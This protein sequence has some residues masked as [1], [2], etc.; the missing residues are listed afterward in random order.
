MSSTILATAERIVHR[1]I[2]RHGLEADAMF[3]SAGLDPQKLNEPQARYPLDRSRELW[4]QINEQIHDPCW[5]LAA[6]DLWRPT[7]F[8]ALGYAYLA[9][10]TLESALKRMERYFRIVIPVWSL[11][12]SITGDGFSMTHVLLPD[13]VNFPASQDA[14]LSIALRMCRDVYGQEFS[15]REVRLA[16]PWQACGYEDFFGCPVRYD[17]DFAGFTVPLDV[18]R[19]PL[20]AKNRDLARENDRILQDL[21]R[22]LL[23]GSM[24]GRVK[25]AILDSR[26]KAR[27]LAADL[28]TEAARGRNHLSDFARCRPQGTRGTLHP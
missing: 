6:G 23:D 18:V 20:P 12:S 7:D 25:N 15:F 28:A 1:L 21:E 11:Q 27:C 17:A 22:R 8:H 3:L 10:G 16:H 19:R 5:G 24:L 2:E 14:R 13:A 4:R 9:S 26:P